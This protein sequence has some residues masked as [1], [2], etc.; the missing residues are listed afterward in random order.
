MRASP[1]WAM[2][3]YFI[4]I[5]E[6]ISLVV[7]GVAAPLDF[8]SAHGLTAG[9]QLMLQIR[10]SSANVRSTVQLATVF[11]LATRIESFPRNSGKGKQGPPSRGFICF[12]KARGAAST[13]A[14][15]FG[16]LDLEQKGQLP[17]T[18]MT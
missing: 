6:V 13:C 15:F 1:L 7:G 5:S 18:V 2:R 3:V 9:P 16:F 14:E 17:A 12:E 4:K 10:L 8:C 11:V